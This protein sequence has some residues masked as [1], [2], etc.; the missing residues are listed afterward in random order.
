MLTLSCTRLLPLPP[1]LCLLNDDRAIHGRLFPPANARNRSR[2][3]SCT[4][5]GARVPRVKIPRAQ[6]PSRCRY[7]GGYG[8]TSARILQE[9]LNA[10]ACRR[11]RPRWSAR[12]TGLSVIVSHFFPASASADA[13]AGSLPSSARGPSRR[14][15]GRDWNPQQDGTCARTRPNPLRGAICLLPERGAVGSERDGEDVVYRALALDL[16]VAHRN[17][18]AALQ[19]R[20]C[21]VVL[22]HGALFRNKKCALRSFIHS[23][24]DK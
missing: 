20:V 1:S 13:R 22:S 11:S 5:A 23:M 6:A 21:V 4:S 2:A 12:F 14:R 9:N 19:S 15:R 18:C 16:S 17:I 7:A 3:N 24:D 8:L 10:L